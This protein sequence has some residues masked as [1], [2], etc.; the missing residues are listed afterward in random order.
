MNTELRND[1][2]EL[3]D[4]TGVAETL[5]PGEREQILDWLDNGDATRRE[6]MLMKLMAGIGAWFAS[7]FVL[8]AVVIGL[9]NDSGFIAVVVGALLM[10]GSVPVMHRRHS[11]VFIDQVGLAVAL[12]GNALVLYG[13][14]D[15]MDNAMFSSLLLGQLAVA[16]IT[17]WFIDHPAYRFVAAALVFLFGSALAHDM[18]SAW[19]MYA[20]IALGLVGM[21]K[22]AAPRLPQLLLPLAHASAVSLAGIFLQLEF[23][24]RASWLG[25]IAF[26]ETPMLV[27]LVISL[28]ALVGRLRREE[29]LSTPG[30]VV[31]IV[32]V[33]VLAIT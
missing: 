24:A 15:S 11:G 4:R 26:S 8:G 12:A 10:A 14:A 22:L 7:W 13:I 27:M 20:V 16:A 19:V 6:P 21:A 33:V 3:L 25:G 5:R 31:S 30:A 23:M 2:A 18:E 9:V 32:L 28:L 29:Q 17:W 1:T